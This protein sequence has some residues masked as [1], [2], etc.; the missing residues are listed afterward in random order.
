[1]H[2]VIPK[3]NVSRFL[4]FVLLAA[5]LSVTGWGSPAAPEMEGLWIRPSLSSLALPVWGHAEGLRVGLWP[6]AGP[7]GLLRIYA[8]YLG[9]ADDRMI[10]YLAVEPIVLG[11]RHRGFSELEMSSLDGVEGLRIWSTD[12]PHDVSPREPTTPARGI[13]THKDGIE[14]LIVYCMVEPF[15]SGARITLRLEFRSDRPYEVGIA[16]LTQPGS[17]PL[18]TCIIT[19]TMGN[20]ARLRIVHLR[21]GSRHAADL[22]SEDPGLGF[23][24]H[25]CFPLAEM[26]RTPSGGALFLATTDEQDPASASYAPGT[27]HGWKYTGEIAT[28]FWRH[29]APSPE[30][31]GC[32]NAR[33]AYWASSSPIPGGLSLENFEL[34]EL[35]RE[36]TVMWFGVRPGLY[37][38]EPLVSPLDAYTP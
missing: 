27:F 9:H 11:E 12:H 23:T 19:A 24:P 8:P 28:Q 5:L 25:A 16:S 18:E 15:Q 13:I 31:I 6:T 32:V 37:H 30:L 4:C 33:S 35:F 2:R 3:H 14:R 26:I 36:G 22:W 7:R 1:M 34:I 38:P 21:T 10:N 20:Y 17:A 29:E